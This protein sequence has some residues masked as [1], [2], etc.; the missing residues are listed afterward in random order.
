M[1]HKPRH[2]SIRVTVQVDGGA[3]YLTGTLLFWSGNG[4]TVPI[5]NRLFLS[6]ACRRAECSSGGFLSRFLGKTRRV[7]RKRH[8][9]LLV[10]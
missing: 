10:Q 2:S 8:I 3:A 6:R 5:H 1:Q 7:R 9:R 4:S